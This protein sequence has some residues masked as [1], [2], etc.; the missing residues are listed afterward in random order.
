MSSCLKIKYEKDLAMYGRRP[1]CQAIAFASVHSHIVR[2]CACAHVPSK[3]SKL[4][5]LKIHFR[6]LTAVQVTHLIAAY[7]HIGRAVADT[8]SNSR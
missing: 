7:I 4:D 2:M 1:D 3:V 5:I 6:R 8:A